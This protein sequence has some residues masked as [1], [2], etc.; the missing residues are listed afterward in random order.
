M[1]VVCIL[2]IFSIYLILILW[3]IS[4]CLCYGFYCIQ[5]FVKNA[6]N[7]KIGGEI[8]RLVFVD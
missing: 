5:G 4:S 8:I 6:D 1:V 3:V 7:V 2:I